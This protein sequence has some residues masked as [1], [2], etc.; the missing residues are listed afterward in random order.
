MRL[1]RLTCLLALTLTVAVGTSHAEPLKTHDQYFRHYETGFYSG[2]DAEVSPEADAEKSEQDDPSVNEESKA[3]PDR[4]AQLGLDS[5]EQV[6]NFLYRRS[7]RADIQS[8]I[9]RDRSGASYLLVFGR[10]IPHQGQIVGYVDRDLTSGSTK[11][12]VGMRPNLTSGPFD[13]DESDYRVEAIYPL[14]DMEQEK[15]VI[16]FLRAN[17]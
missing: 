14:E 5:V 8:V 16:K 11:I 3:L 7:R 6:D 15:R 13:R 10:S 4:Y 9:V 17:N 12:R 1:H 2:L